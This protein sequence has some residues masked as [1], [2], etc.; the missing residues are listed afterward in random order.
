M[1]KWFPM[2]TPMA[3]TG[4]YRRTRMALTVPDDLRDCLDDLAEAL[5]KPA[6]TLAVEFLREMIPQF[7]ALAK[8]ARAAKRGD[9]AAIKRALVHM[10]G[11]NLAEMMAAQQPDM[12]PP[13]KAKK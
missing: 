3:T 11:D 8:M 7:Q 12:F 5:E 10:V 9:K 6:A 2:A 4:N 13:K 1:A